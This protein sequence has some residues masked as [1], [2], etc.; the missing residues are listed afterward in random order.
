MN[1]D[2]IK[3][4]AAVAELISTVAAIQRPLIAFAK[5]YDAHWKAVTESVAKFAEPFFHAAQSAA[6]HL[7]ANLGP[8][9]RQHAKLKRLEEAGWLPHYTSPLSLIP[10]IGDVDISSLMERHYTDNWF[11][12]KA[13]L[14]D[15]V[16]S[17]DIDEEAKETFSE[18]VCAHE[19]G[20]FR[21]TC[22]TLFP[23]IERVVRVELL[24]G[25]LHGIASMKELQNVAGQLGLSEMRP[26]GLSGM[27]LYSRLVDHIYVPAHTAEDVIKLAED[28]VPNRHAAMHG[29]VSYKTF[30]NSINMLTMAD[31][32]FHVVSAT[33]INRR[34]R[35]EASG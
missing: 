23:E 15:G 12:I 11:D 19:Q 27:A 2:K 29:L 31:F 8:V 30:K 20:L 7:E 10:D 1:D 18:A 6:K 13:K 22:R 16:K 35:D 3:S 28:D 33:K 26:T 25:S 24:E 32:M 5:Q 21:A 34:A 14:L 17:Y 4:N 9:L